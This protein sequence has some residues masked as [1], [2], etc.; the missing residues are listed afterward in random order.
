[1]KVEENKKIVKIIE[2]TKGHIYSPYSN[3]DHKIKL[4][5]FNEILT[6]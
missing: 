3:P 1:M 4:T 2:T 6:P 5:V